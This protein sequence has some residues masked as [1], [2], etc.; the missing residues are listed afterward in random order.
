MTIRE[1]PRRPLGATGLEVSV[2]ALGALEIG[3]DWAA[4]VDPNP[5]HLSESEAISFVHAAID[6]GINLIDTA[7]AYW[8]SEEYL[9]KAL[10]G[11]RDQVVLATK[12]GEHCD[13]SGS[14]YDYSY[15]A[16]LRFIEQSLRRL[17]TDYVDLIQ[18]HSAP[19]DVLEKGE[20]YEALCKARD[21]G[22]VLHIGMT[23]GARE[24]ARALER[25]GYET[26]QVPYNLLN[27]A[28]EQ[29]VFPLAH[30]RKAGVLVMRG[31]A[32]GKLTEK[33]V[34]LSGSNLKA[35]IASFE[36]FLGSGGVFS[37]AHLAL[38]YV[39]GSPDVSSVLVGTRK[40]EHL[41]KAIAAAWHPLAGE[42]IEELHAHA[43][44]LGF[45]VW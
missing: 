18:I 20:T 32:G 26:V 6:L 38:G 43:T 35:K 1:V 36:K 27:L 15:G 8:H 33:Y 45:N 44:A 41:E 2:I 24:C 30:K 16:T 17:Q 21:E 31:L 5:H 42:L 10:K 37:L 3:R 7:P 14:Y 11:R 13:P 28:P 22:K 12:V 19:L 29:L 23:G 39:L 4:D 9:G 34:N 25:G 40:I